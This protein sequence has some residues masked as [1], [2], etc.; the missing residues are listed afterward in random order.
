[1][2]K[3]EL[4]VLLALVRNESM[5]KESPFRKVGYVGRNLSFRF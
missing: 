2:F 5:T 1:M 4:P 3:G